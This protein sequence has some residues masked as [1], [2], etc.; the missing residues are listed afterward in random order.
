[1]R[2]LFYGGGID[3]LKAQFVGS[4]TC[5][6]IVGAVALG[7]MYLVKATGTLRVSKDG[8]LEGLDI[9]EHGTAPY[10]VELGQGMTFST[11][12]DLPRREEIT[13]VEG[14]ADERTQPPNSVWTASRSRVTRS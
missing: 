9:H 1:M 10:R 14:S 4:I 7:L 2:G 6:V 12:A 13:V 5:V 11:P 3:Q 8:E